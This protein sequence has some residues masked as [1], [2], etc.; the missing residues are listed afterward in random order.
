MIFLSNYRIGWESGSHYGF[1]GKL[2]LIPGLAHPPYNCKGAVNDT[3]RK[4]EPKTRTGPKNS[5]SCSLHPPTTNLNTTHPRTTSTIAN[6]SNTLRNRSLNL[7]RTSGYYRYYMSTSSK[8]PQIRLFF[9]TIWQNFTSWFERTSPSGVFGRKHHKS[10]LKNKKSRV[11]TRTWGGIMLSSILTKI[12]SCV[13]VSRIRVAYNTNMGLGQ[14]GFRT[15]KKCQDGNY[16]L[17]L[18]HQWCRKQH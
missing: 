10:Y 15:G 4:S 14:M 2:A 5:F 17:K 3:S 1:I 9:Q 8:S 11:D 13:F 18:I 7:H 6:N 16:C 12:L